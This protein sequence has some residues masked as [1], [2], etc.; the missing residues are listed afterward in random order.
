V[1]PP[2][3]HRDIWDPERPWWERYQPISYKL[4]SRSGN[5]SQFIDMVQRCNAV[6]VR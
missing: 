4:H 2:N 6:N 3:E 1:S 5:E